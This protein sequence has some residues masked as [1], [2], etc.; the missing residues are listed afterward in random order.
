MKTFKIK[1]L[2][3]SQ[4]NID[5][6]KTKKCTLPWEKDGND[7]TNM[8]KHARYTKGVTEGLFLVNEM[9]D[10]L[11]GYIGWEGKKIIAIEVTNDYQRL[12]YGKYLMD[13]AINAGCTWLTVHKD[14]HKA[15]G[16]Y[17]KYGFHF[18]KTRYGDNIR[19]KINKKN[20]E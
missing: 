13:K 15:I 10:S 20:D 9:D 11:V 17:L 19:M 14:N 4:E 8:L 1:K 7:K 3:Y 12:G 16:F 18:T 2:P 6:Y 5:K